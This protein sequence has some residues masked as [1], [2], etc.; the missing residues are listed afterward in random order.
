V[1]D[2]SDYSAQI[3]IG[4]RQIVAN[5]ILDTGSSTL[6]VVPSIYHADDDPDMK[7]SSLAQHVSYQDG[8]GWLGPVLRTAVTFGDPA[9]K[10]VTANNVPVAVPAVQSRGDFVGVDGIMGLAY[11]SINP[12]YDLQAYLKSRG[13]TRGECFPWPFRSAI[14]A[15]ALRRFNE[16]VRS[17]GIH[18]G[19][20]EPYFNALEQHGLT[21]DK[22]AF[23]T[24]RS[25]MRNASQ[26]QTAN[27]RDPLNHGWFILGG[28]E[29][30]RDLY[31]GSFADVAVL[32]D[33]W[34]NVELKAIQVGSCQPVKALPLQAAYKAEDGNSNCVVDS[35]SSPTTLSNDV[36]N[37]MMK[38]FAKLNPKFVR[39]IQQAHVK[40][41]SSALD[42]NEWPDISFI[43]AGKQGRNVKLTCTP[44][45]YWQDHNP[46]FDTSTF[47]IQAAGPHAPD[48]ASTL[49]LTVLNNYYTIFDRSAGKGKGIIRFAPIAR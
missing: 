31:T 1:L 6:A 3:R 29:Q 7:P 27:M 9:N 37:A 30:Q 25:L 5:V 48:H 11:Y 21:L 10:S 4:R 15:R 16:L 20:V 43:L 26:N 45:T 38:S 47:Q 8:S 22:F 14:F 17:H 33:V 12:T 2:G 49:G 24:R 44:Q 36:Y 34:Y 32:H 19:S 23:Y 28:G 35:G 40:I 39:L 18:Q 13:V 42:L 46:D 41:A